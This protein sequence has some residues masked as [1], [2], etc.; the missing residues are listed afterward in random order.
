MRERKELMLEHGPRE[1]GKDAIMLPVSHMGSGKG[2]TQMGT[3]ELRTPSIPDT[4]RKF[5]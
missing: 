2:A 1:T 5:V 4:L 3:Q